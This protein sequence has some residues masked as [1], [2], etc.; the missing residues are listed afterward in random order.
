MDLVYVP[1]TLEAGSQ[2]WEWRHT[3]VCVVPVRSQ[4]KSVLLRLVKR[5]TSYLVHTNSIATCPQIDVGQCCVYDFFKRHKW[6]KTTNKQNVTATWILRS[7]LVGWA[8]LSELEIQLQEGVAVEISDEELGNSNFKVQLFTFYWNVP[9]I[10]LMSLGLLPHMKKQCQLYS[11]IQ[12]SLYS[13]LCLTGQVHVGSSCVEAC[14]HSQDCQNTLRSWP[15]ESFTSLHTQGESSIRCV[16]SIRCLSG[17][18]S[19]NNLSLLMHARVHNCNFRNTA[20]PYFQS[21][22]SVQ[23]FSEVTAIK[24]ISFLFIC[25]AGVQEVERVIH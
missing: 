2:S 22:L 17:H 4:K 1:L 14:H 3:G 8:R 11:F 24:N 23:L 19:Q 9:F 6:D 7:E 12:S 5:I 10:E 16:G 15:K 21:S 25:E 20:S 13:L 18:N